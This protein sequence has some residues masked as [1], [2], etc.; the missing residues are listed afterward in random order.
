[1]GSSKIEKGKKTGKDAGLQETEEQYNLKQVQIT[2]PRHSR[3]NQSLP[4]GRVDKERKGQEMETV[5]SEE[6]YQE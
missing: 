5:Q 2:V 4:C 1:M 6:K 3:R